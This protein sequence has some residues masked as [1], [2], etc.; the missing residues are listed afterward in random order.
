MVVLGALSLVFAA[1][2][3]YFMTEEGFGRQEDHEHSSWPSAIGT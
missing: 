1:S 3:A 2:L